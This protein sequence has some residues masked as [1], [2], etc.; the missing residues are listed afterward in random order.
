MSAA[1]ILP[2]SWLTTTLGAIRVDQSTSIDPSK[3]KAEQF[4]L[5][6]I[7]AFPSGRPEIVAGSE[8]GSTKKSLTP[9]TVVISKINPRI[10]RV[11]VVGDHSKH[12][13]IGSSEWIPFFPVSG[14]DP[15]Y[16]AYYMR[17]DALRNYLAARVSGVGGSLMRVRPATIDRFP[18]VIA[19][20]PEQQRIVNALESYF[21]RLDDAV[22]TLERLQRNLKRYRASVLKAAVEGR[23]VPTEAEVARAEGRSYEPASVLLERILA[24]RRRRWEEAELASM[25]AE[26]KTLKDTNWKAKYVEPLAPDTT[27]LAEL[28][29]GWCWATLAQVFQTIA[30]GDHQP[31]PQTPD[32][33]PFLVIGNVRSGCVNLSDTR[34]VSHAYYDSL[35]V[36]RKPRDGD[37]LYTVTGSYGIPVRVVNDLA[38]CVQRHIAILRPTVLSNSAFLYYVLQSQPVFE[39]ATRKATGTAQKTV[40]LQSLRN[41]VIPL[42]PS[43]EQDRIV[44]SLEDYFSLADKATTDVV[45]S[46]LR[47]ARLRQS[48]LKWAFD[49]R[50]VDQDPSDEPASVLL[51]RLRTERTSASSAPAAD[52]AVGKSLRA[53]RRKLKRKKS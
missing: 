24:E 30:D 48:I 29:D 34:F 39:Q 35:D 49:G 7:P 3:A 40:G 6:S 52:S 26:G 37:L 31:P 47:G 46:A 38:F 15:H 12:P 28:P 23:L 20:E 8:I 41:M 25:I 50:L 22:V 9:G 11:W 16:L 45:S 53:Q 36:R 33:I 10:S 2:D 21:T 17:Q 44:A 32:G 43:P 18:I 14:I 51:E 4:E 1:K 27:N 5:Y 42:P 13:K 19:P